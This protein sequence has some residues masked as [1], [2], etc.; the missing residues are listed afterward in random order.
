MLKL[1]VGKLAPQV[2]PLVLFVLLLLLGPLFHGDDQFV[3]LVDMHLEIVARHTRSGDFH[4]IFVL[5][6]EDVDGR[7]RGVVAFGE[8][9]AAQKIV[10]NARQPILITSYRYHSFVLLGFILV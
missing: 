9:F 8:P 5:I 1:R 6:L 3:V 2:G 7:S 10:E 4:L